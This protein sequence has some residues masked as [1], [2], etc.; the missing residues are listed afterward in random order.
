[1]TAAISTPGLGPISTL[2][3]APVYVR[4]AGAALLLGA[5]AAVAPRGGAR[6]PRH[7]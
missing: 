7:C 1:M 6:S 3:R 2:M 5:C 4:I